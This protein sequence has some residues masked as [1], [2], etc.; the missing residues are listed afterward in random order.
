[1]VQQSTGQKRIMTVDPECVAEI[2]RITKWQ[3]VIAESMGGLFPEQIDLS[4]VQHILDVACGSGAWALEVAFKYPALAVTGVDSNNLIIRYAQAQAQ[5]QCLKNARF[6][7]MDVLSGLDFSP[8]TFDMVNVQ[9]LI[10]CI[11]VHAW[12]GFLQEGLRVLRPGGVMR[13]TSSE[14]VSTS[15][16]AYEE[17]LH[18]CMLALHKAGFYPADNGYYTGLTA[19]HGHLLK[20]L[21]YQRVQQQAHVVYFSHGAASCEDHYTNFVVQMQLLKPF[22]LRMEVIAEERFEMLYREAT[23]DLLSNDHYG[24]WYFMTT[25]GEAPGCP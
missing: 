6:Q 13:I 15:S 9:T 7:V 25:W 22:L 3:K 18:A 2:A 12:P 10:D 14:L 1:M 23:I 24:A 21:G 20:R 4:S 11:P 17:L 19:M 5:T 16:K 8:Q